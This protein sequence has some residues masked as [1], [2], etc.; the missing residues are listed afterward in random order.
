MLFKVWF[1]CGLFTVCSHVLHVVLL[2]R[3]I[4]RT[5][6]GDVVLGTPTGVIFIPPHLAEAVATRS[7]E[8]RL[9]DYW[10]KLMIS[11]GKYTPG[12]IDRKWPEEIEAD[13]EKWSE[14][15]SLEDIDA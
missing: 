3:Q 14:T 12:E 7:E 6:P 5:L 4:G 1:P 9:R 11:Q 10:G 2:R 13:F 8:I 15:H